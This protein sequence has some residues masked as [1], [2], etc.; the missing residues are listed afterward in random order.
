MDCAWNDAIRDG[1]AQAFTNA[2]A[3]FASKDHPLRYLWLEFVPNTPM[4]HLWKPLYAKIRELLKDMPIL[5]TWKGRIFK[6]P[7]ELKFL[8]PCT[9]H[10]GAPIFDDLPNEKYLAPE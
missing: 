2:I 7:S 10:H 8:I 1:V 9:L 3:K 5:Q 6:R 4:E